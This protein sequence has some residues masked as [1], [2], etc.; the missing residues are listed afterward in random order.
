[1][2]SKFL[3]GNQTALTDQRR[4][5]VVL[6]FLIKRHLRQLL[7][8]DYIPICKKLSTDTKCIPKRISNTK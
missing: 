1:M 7:V 3:T 6:Q 5:N 8:S 2:S 4:L